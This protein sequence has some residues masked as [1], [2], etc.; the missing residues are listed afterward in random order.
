MKSTFT[1]KESAKVFLL[2]MFLLIASIKTFAYDFEIDGI[3]YRVSS[4]IDHECAVTGYKEI[5]NNN[6]IIPASITWNNIKYSVVSIEKEAFKSCSKVTSIVIPESVTSIGSSAFEG[7]S[8]LTSIN[9]PS[10]I[11]SIEHDTFCGCSGLTS[12][13]IPS[14]VT[15]IE[16]STFAGCSALTSIN[17]PSGVT[18][19]GS[20]AFSGCI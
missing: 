4:E 20:G 14:G 5:T 17:I 8:G 3:C 6:L 16:Y 11:T 12:V 19:I 15:T 2:T 10:G 13:N 7:C 18:I 9:I 1:L